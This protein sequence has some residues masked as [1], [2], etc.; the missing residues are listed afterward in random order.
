MARTIAISFKKT[1]DAPKSSS[2]FYRIGKMVGKGAF[3][4]VNL[5]M[6]KISEQFVAIKS[7][8]KTYLEEE[9]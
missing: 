9:G 3:G 8:N 7:I 1:N 2:D 6:Q 5:A 4:K